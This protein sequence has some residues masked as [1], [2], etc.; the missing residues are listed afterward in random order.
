[1][2]VTGI[3]AVRTYTPARLLAAAGERGAGAPVPRFSFGGL[4]SIAASPLGWTARSAV[5]VAIGSCGPASVQYHEEERVLR[6]SG[7]QDVGKSQTPIGYAFCKA[8]R[9]SARRGGA[10]RSS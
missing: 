1:M 2:I 7:R 6:G 10:E 9:S 8:S 3:E 4:D 5:G